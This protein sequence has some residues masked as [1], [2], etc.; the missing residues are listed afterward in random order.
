MGAVYPSNSKSIW[1]LFDL[2]DPAACEHLHKQRALWREESDLAALGPD[3]IVLIIRPG[4][5]V[6]EAA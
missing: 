5:A 2:R 1:I 4:T 3:H 6:R